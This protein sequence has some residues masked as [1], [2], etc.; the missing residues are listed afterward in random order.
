MKKIFIAKTFISK[1]ATILRKG[2][3]PK[4]K[5]PESNV[6]IDAVEKCN[7]LPRAADSN[8]IIIVKLK[9]KLPYKDHVYFESVSPHFI[10]SLLE[11]LKIYNP[12]TK[13]IHEIFQIAYPVKGVQKVF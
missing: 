8:V 1:K 5:G 12:L 9:G 2:Q 11:F 7:S 6:P 3:S 10:I 4:L 13:Y